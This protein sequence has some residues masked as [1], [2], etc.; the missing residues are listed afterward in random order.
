MKCKKAMAV[1]A[2]L[3]LVFTALSLLLALSGA[4]T[5]V[6][7]Q[8]VERA[9]ILRGEDDPD[10]TR[11][12]LLPGDRVDINHADVETLVLLPGVGEAIAGEI[13]L[14]RQ[15]EGEFESIEDIMNVEG[16]G[17]ARFEEL[18]EWIF[19]GESE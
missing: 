7:T 18:A 1:C 15:Q 11:E 3:A 13:V 17:P 4:D 6:R 2:V 10:D 5:P 19:T 16:I 9:R 12:Q 8:G 14:Y